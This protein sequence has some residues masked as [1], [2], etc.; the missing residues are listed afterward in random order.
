MMNYIFRLLVY[1][2]FCNRS[3]LQVP[4]W[5]AE[6]LSGHQ[7]HHRVKSTVVSPPTQLN[8]L[9]NAGG[10]IISASAMQFSNSGMLNTSSSSQKNLPWD[11]NSEESSSKEKLPEP[12]PS[13]WS[14]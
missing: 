6:N 13:L 2:I 10:V 8:P 11:E 3:K 4:L 14:C 12:D 5:F 7:F 1:I 9:S